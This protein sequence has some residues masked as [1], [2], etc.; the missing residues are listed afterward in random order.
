MPYGSALNL[1]LSKTLARSLS[2]FLMT[3]A[4]V[5]GSFRN[6]QGHASF[7]LADIQVRARS[8]AVRATVWRTKM[9]LAFD[10]PYYQRNDKSRTRR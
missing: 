9:R 5:Q 8:E 7:S 1:N 2:L 6:E 3:S 4:Q 10:S